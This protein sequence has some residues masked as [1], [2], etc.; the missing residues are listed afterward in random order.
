MILLELC[1]NGAL[2][3]GLNSPL[4][5]SLRVRLALDTA[6]GLAFLHENNIVHRY[7]ITN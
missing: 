3:E 7:K 2:R 1:T 5:W 6:V 4:P